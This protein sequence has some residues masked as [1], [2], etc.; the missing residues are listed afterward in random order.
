M[1]TERCVRNIDIF[2]RGI[3]YQPIYDTINDVEEIMTRSLDGCQ[4]TVEGRSKKVKTKVSGK[5]TK[6]VSVR[7]KKLKKKIENL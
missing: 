3:H 5:K 7:G 2:H 6:K 1:G 4:E